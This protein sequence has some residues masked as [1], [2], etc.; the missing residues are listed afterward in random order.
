MRRLGLLLVLL[1][2]PGC[3][4]T[5]VEVA[6]PEDVVVVEAFLEAGDSVQW[7]FLHRTLGSD[8]GTAVES[9][10]VVVSGPSGDSLLLDPAEDSVCFTL[11]QPEDPIS[12]S[13]Y[14]AVGGMEVRPGERYSL[15]VDLPDGGRIVGETT[16]PAPFQVLQ[17]APDTCLLRDPALD[18]IW[19]EAL[20]AAAYQVDALL[21]NLQPG[22]A[23]RGV[24]DPPDLL[25]LI[26]FALGSSDTT[27]AFPAELGVFDRFGLDR[28]LLLALRQGLPE[29][30]RADIVVAAVDPN[31]VNWVRGGTFNPS[32]Q[33]RVPSVTGDGVGVFGSLTTRTRTLIVPDESGG[34]QGMP[35]CQ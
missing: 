23:A 24:E 26:G 33:V 30:G 31:Y 22:L 28:E 14:A 17:P 7:A 11:E 5:T 29:E 4:L 2:V 19:T 16:V 32:G 25:R 27:L 13:C 21:S 3:E 20:G 8:R 10:R 15:H 9:A 12:G 34:D 18:L 6:E 1:S 35:S